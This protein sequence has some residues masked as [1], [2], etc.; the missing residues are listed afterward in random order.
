[1]KLNLV[2]IALLVAMA[3]ALGI[4]GKAAW[5]NLKLRVANTALNA[6]LMEAKLEIGRANTKFGEASDYIESLGKNLQAEIKARQAEVTRYGELLAQ[7]N[8][9]NKL[10]GKVEIVYKDKVVIVPKELQLEPGVYRVNGQELT[11]IESLKK[12]FETPELTA[13]CEY[14][15]SEDE[16][17]LSYD[18]HLKFKGQLVETLTPSGAINHYFNM[19][20]IDEDGDEL[21]KLTLTD[22]QVV[23]IDERNP[24]FFWWTP[25]FDLGL[26]LT[27]NLEPR[28]SAGGSFGFSIMG[29]GLTEHELSWRFLRFGI[30]W[31]GDTGAVSFDPVAFN[32]GRYIPWM[33]D[34]Y[35]SPHAAWAFDNNWWFGL[36][37]GTT[38]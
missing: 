38:L 13:T 4:V 20:T 7:Y 33:H 10:K 6:E 16:M 35:I 36:M 31:I 9:V 30:D 1:M 25:H 26:V 18:L 11:L 8:K 14:N 22:F 5:T 3:V 17:T 27:M 23:V 28:I 29:Y 37:I 21:D 15:C 2:L 12:D 24:Q 19:W 34:L 32:F